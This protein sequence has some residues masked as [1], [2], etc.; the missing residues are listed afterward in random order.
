MLKTL[1]TKLKNIRDWRPMKTYNVAEA[2]K[3]VG[4]NRSIIYGR[5]HKGTLTRPLT[6]KN[7]DPIE[8]SVRHTKS[9]SMI[10]IVRANMVEIT[11]L[12]HAGHNIAHIAKKFDVSESMI[13]RECV[14]KYKQ[15]VNRFDRAF[16]LMNQKL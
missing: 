9:A 14:P 15:K 4:C 5:L 12:I 6:A 16:D 11:Q 7:L 1:L 3:Y 13:E 10:S 8:L 2:A